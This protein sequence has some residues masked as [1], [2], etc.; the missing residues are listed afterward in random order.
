MNIDN[1]RGIYTITQTSRTPSNND[2]GNWFKNLKSLGVG[3]F[4]VS[5]TFWLIVLVI[6]IIGIIPLTQ[7][8]VGSV[9]KNNCPMNYLIPIYLIVAGVIGLFIIIISIIQVKFLFPCY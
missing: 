4:S 7:L 5:L 1:E 3:C 8:I 6:A 2:Q 9:H